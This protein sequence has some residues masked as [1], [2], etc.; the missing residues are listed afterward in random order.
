[1]QITQTIARVTHRADT[2]MMYRIACLGISIALERQHTRESAEVQNT[3]MKRK[4]GK[5]GDGEEK[6]V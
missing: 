5:K 3:T 1:M 4:E 6:T 2:H